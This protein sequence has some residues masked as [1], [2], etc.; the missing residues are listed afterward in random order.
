VW[1]GVVWRGLVRPNNF[2]GENGEN[3]ETPKTQNLNQESEPEWPTRM[4]ETD[5][6]LNAES[7]ESKDTAKIEFII[8]PS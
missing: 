3:R 7:T 2:I 8:L 1:I 6:H 5:K 4:E